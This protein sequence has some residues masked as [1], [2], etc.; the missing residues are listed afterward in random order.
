MNK[1]YY[2][3]YQVTN[4]VN[5]KV[6]I[7]THKTRSLDDNYMGS[8]KYLR[9]AIEKHGPEQFTKEILFVYDNPKDMYAKEAELVN[10]DFLAEANTYNLRVGGSGGW[11]YVNDSGLNGTEKGVQTAIHLRDDQE[12][13]TFWKKRHAE[14]I[15]AMSAEK[16]EQMRKKISEANRG[17]PGSFKGKSHSAE[18]RNKM[19]KKMKGKLVGEKNP[20][21][22]TC[23]IYNLS[24][25]TNKVV[26]KTSLCEYLDAGWLQGRIQDFEKHLKSIEEEK[27]R[28]FEQT[29]V[30]LNWLESKRNETIQ[31]YMEFCNSE[32]TSIREFCDS[33]LYPFS[34]WN[35]MKQFRSHLPNF[36]RIIGRPSEP[37]KKVPI[38]ELL[39]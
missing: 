33:E 7:G 2:T 12:W 38:E 5:G 22:G 16:K 39:N 21:Y 29:Q 9:R 14:G 18:A 4:Q 19:S 8:G 17:Q 15:A 1:L 26:Q 23:W 6:Y 27:Q 32:Y 35:L 20:R 11:G 31:I 30:R 34:R 10:E 28:Q 36:E 37:L 13:M 25:R 3:V 24:L